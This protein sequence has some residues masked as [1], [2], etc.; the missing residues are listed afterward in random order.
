MKEDSWIRDLKEHSGDI[1]TLQWSPAGKG[2]QL[3][4]TYVPLLPPPS[5]SLSLTLS[6]HHRA[7]FDSTVR[8]WDAE[9]GAC[10]HTLRK[11]QDPVYSISFSNDG[12]YIASGSFDKWTFIWSTSDGSLVRQYKADSGIF[13][14]CWNK[15]SSQLAASCSDN[16]VSGWVWSTLERE[17]EVN[18][19]LQYRKLLF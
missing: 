2:N 18:Y 6:Y 13:E 1:Y 5:L 9:K 17:R 16:T 7:S 10:V 19:V 8:L 14:V 12:R 3:L 15:D 11:H 4:A